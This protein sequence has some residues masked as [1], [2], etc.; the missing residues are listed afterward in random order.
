MP[1]FAAILYSNFSVDWEV[2]GSNDFGRSIPFCRRSPYACFV[3]RQNIEQFR[4]AQPIKVKACTVQAFSVA[5]D[6]ST[7]SFLLTCFSRASLVAFFAASA[8]A[9]ACLRHFSTSDLTA[10]VSAISD[11]LSGGG[12]TRREEVS[13]LGWSQAGILKPLS[14]ASMRHWGLGDM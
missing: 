11:S 9:R 13:S 2:Q 12:H 6:R 10:A 1:F 3:L 7:T 14:M 4:R 5:E 8:A